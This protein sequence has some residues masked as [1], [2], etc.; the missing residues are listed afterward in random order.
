MIREIK[1]K[2]WILENRKPYDAEVARFFGEMNRADWISSSLKLDGSNLP[3]SDIERII[4]GEFLVHV[5]I[6]EH[7]AIGAFSDAI[8]RMEEM[9]AMD[10][11]LDEK[12][13]R[14]IHESL[15]PEEESGYRR[16]NPVLPMLSYNPPHFFEIEEQLSLL[17]Q[18][19][20]HETEELNPFETAAFFHNK[21]IEIY[22]FTNGSEATARAAAQYLLLTA[23][24]PPIFW[25]SSETEYYDAI[26]LYLKNEE[27]EP[28]Y[29]VLLRG[30]Y[31]K[32]EVMM[33]LTA[34]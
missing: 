10:I 33:Q 17:F 2:K 24:Y 13:L 3:K 27:I 8:R 16:T 28:I 5:P 20:Y 21:L 18:W 31:N 34:E 22:P 30:V 29:E 23:G 6:G 12:H 15:F 4:K 11:S 25:N 32:L 7:A 19:L 9:A 26:R 14:I 1:K